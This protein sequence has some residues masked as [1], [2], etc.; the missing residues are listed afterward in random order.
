MEACT[1]HVATFV[2]TTKR[3]VLEDLEK[4]MAAEKISAPALHNDPEIHGIATSSALMAAV[5]PAKSF[6]D[7]TP[8]PASQQQLLLS[9]PTGVTEASSEDDC[10]FG[11]SMD[12]MLQQLLNLAT[13]WLLHYQHN[14]S[15]GGEA[16]ITEK[17]ASSDTTAVYQ[18]VMQKLQRGGS[19][20]INSPREET[21]AWVIIEHMLDGLHSAISHREG[22]AGSEVPS[23]FG[24]AVSFSLCTC[25][26]ASRRPIGPFRR[27][28]KNF[29]AGAE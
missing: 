8:A 17:N 21:Q 4:I 27:G 15:A 29:L 28:T 1:N 26:T 5:Q 3:Q 12:P 14:D 23:C 10:A 22:S 25:S 16:P 9:Q 11:T 24:G 2:S 18:Q 7:V 6:V 13:K 19:V 20:E